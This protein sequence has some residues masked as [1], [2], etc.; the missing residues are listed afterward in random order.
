MAVRVLLDGRPL[1]RGVTGIPRYAGVLLRALPRLDQTRDYAVLSWRREA[2]EVRDRLDGMSVVASPI[3]GRL[4]VHLQNAAGLSIPTWR[5][6][7]VDVFHATSFD[8]IRLK[9]AST[10]ATFHDVQFLRVPESYPTAARSAFDKAVR[11]ALRYV[12]HVITVSNYA[13]TDI[14]SAYGISPDRISVAYPALDPLVSGLVDRGRSNGHAR[15]GGAYLLYVGEVGPRKNLQR[16]IAAFA[17]IAGGVP[18]DLLIVGP[19]G[20]TEGYTRELRSEAA[21]RGVANRVYF[22]G[23]AGDDALRDLYAGCD[24]FVFP[25]LY[26]SFGFP[27]VEAMSWGKPTVA[28]LASAVPEIAGDGALLVD[29]LSPDSIADGIYAVLT[30][31]AM[32]QRLM[33]LGRR[34]AAVFTEDNM[35]R[36]ICAA[37]EKVA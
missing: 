36:G 26:E 20:A 21:R 19:P 4:M 34:R 13:K 17:R 29:P 7:H 15:H 18:H 27:I 22:F 23:P 6:G 16:L 31:D 2:P 14:S 11:S 30:D 28:S 5:L 12:D 24:A 3:P 10:I 33:A 32:R 37:Y 25:S 35:V 1:L 9:N 8:P